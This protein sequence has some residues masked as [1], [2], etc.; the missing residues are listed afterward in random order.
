V[1]DS[2]LRSNPESTV[3]LYERIVRAKLFVDAHYAKDLAVGEI[4]SEAFLSRFHFIRLFKRIYSRT[5]HQY[6]TQVRIERAKDLLNAGSPVSDVCYS[7][8][9]ES[10]SSFTGLFKRLVGWTPS[11]YRN[12]QKEIRAKIARNPLQFVPGCFAQMNGLLE[13][14][15]FGE[16]VE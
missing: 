16:G 10:E 11:A 15:N 6:L 7:V 2:A 9:F 8:G 13:K 12:R 5:P 14:S 1:R 3:Y 4:A